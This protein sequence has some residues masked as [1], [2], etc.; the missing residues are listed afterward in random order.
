[1]KKLAMFIGLFLFV[2]S[3]AVVAINF[4]RQEKPL[5]NSSDDNSASPSGKVQIEEL[6]PG[7]GDAVKN[8]DSVT[9]HYTGTLTDGTQFDS[10]YDRE[11]FT[12]TVGSGSVIQGWD[13]GIIGMKV[14]EKRKLTIPPDLGYGSV[15]QGSIPANS[16]LLFEIEL[17]SIDTA[18]ENSQQ[19]ELNL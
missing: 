18:K 8:G 4:P 10:S 15:Q 5:V 1:M 7:T 9:V 2:Y 11:P 17:I 16:T 14:G 13:E 19:P 3:A 12:F 6:Q